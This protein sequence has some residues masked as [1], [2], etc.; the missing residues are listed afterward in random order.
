[1]SNLGNKSFKTPEPSDIIYISNDTGSVDG[2][3]TL[4][5][6]TRIPESISRTITVNSSMTATEIQAEIDSIGKH[7]RKNVSITFQFSNGTYNLDNY[8]VFL[9]F[10][11]GGSFFIQ[12]DTSQTDGLHTNHNVHLNFN[13]GSHGVWLFQNTA[14]MFVRH[15]KITT[16]DTYYSIYLART[17]FSNIRYNYLISTGNVGNSRSINVIEGHSADII[18]NYFNN[19]FYGIISVLNSRVLSNNNDTVGT[20][21]KYGLYANTN[22]IIAKSGANQPTGSI[23]NETEANGG[24][25]R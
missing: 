19:S 25:I 20:N 7:I 10:Y 15:L 2:K 13:N 23:A 9:G 4:S 11:G 12:G 24:E 3:T 22:A 21:P 14:F 17:G 6:I 5:T 16:D 1:M 8:L 18:E